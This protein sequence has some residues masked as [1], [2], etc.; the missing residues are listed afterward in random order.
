MKPPRNAVSALGLYVVTAFGMTALVWG[1]PM[2]SFVG[3][4]GDPYKFMSFLGWIPHALSTGHNPLFNGRNRSSTRRQSHRGHSDAA[5]SSRHLA[6]DS[7]SRRGRRLQRLP[8]SSVVV[9][10]IPAHL[11]LIAVLDRSQVELAIAVAD[12]VGPV[13]HGAPR[14]AARR[15][16]H[17]CWIL[18]HQCIAHI[19][20]PFTYLGLLSRPPANGACAG[21]VLGEVRQTKRTS[22]PRAGSTRS[23]APAIRNVRAAGMRAD[24]ATESVD[25]PRG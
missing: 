19:E 7:A 23:P 10:R 18:R 1:H 14:A 5:G 20:C 13:T 11:L 12:N 25:E 16:R 6:G 15:G 4:L 22:P 3:E 17:R 24:D 2:Q 9:R 8:S 21:L